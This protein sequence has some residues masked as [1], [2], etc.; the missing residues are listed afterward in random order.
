MQITYSQQV[1]QEYSKNLAVALVQGRPGIRRP[2]SCLYLV[3]LFLVYFLYLFMVPE[4]PWLSP[5]EFIP[6]DSLVLFLFYV[7]QSFLAAGII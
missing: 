4:V 3:S 7:D 5:L 6:L 2:Y 1:Y